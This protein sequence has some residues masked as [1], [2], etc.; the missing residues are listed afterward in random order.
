MFE[1]KTEKKHRIILVLSWAHS[2]FSLQLLVD[3][4]RMFESLEEKKMQRR[5]G[6][7][8][9]GK[10]L[11]RKKPLETPTTSKSTG[12]IK[13]YTH[14]YFTYM[15]T[16]M[17]T[18]A[19]RVFIF[20]VTIWRRSISL[21]LSS[22]FSRS[23]FFFLVHPFIRSFCSRPLVFMMLWIFSFFDSFITYA[24]ALHIFWLCT[25]TVYTYD[26]KKNTQANENLWI[27]EVICVVY[28]VD[29]IEKRKKEDKKLNE[30]GIGNEC[31]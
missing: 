31:M 6:T 8:D 11:Q 12:Y 15:P 18:Y 25:C 5:E 14:A 4:R 17:C 21:S 23:F 10:T 19:T 29:P 20:R 3:V 16:A 28:G 27:S 9:I 22:L 7:W 26:E 1:K 2:T 13:H 24:P 30:Y